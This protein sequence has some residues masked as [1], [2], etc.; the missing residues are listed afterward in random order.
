MDIDH[1]PTAAQIAD[2]LAV[3]KMNVVTVSSV[4][5]GLWA[6][7]GACDADVCVTTPEKALGVLRSGWRGKPVIVIGQKKDLARGVLPAV[8]VVATPVKH[9]RLVAALQVAVTEHAASTLD[10]PLHDDPSML[11]ELSAKLGAARVQAAGVPAGAPRHSLDNSALERRI[12]LLSEEALQACQQASESQDLCNGLPSC[13]AK[14]SRCWRPGLSTVRSTSSASPVA[15]PASPENSDADGCANGT[16]PEP[17]PAPRILIAEDNAINVRV[18][19][20]V[21]KH[22]R[23][24]AVVDVACNG[25]EVL[26][27]VERVRYDLILMDIHMPGEWKRSLYPMFVA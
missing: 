12:L 26:K 2:S 14:P 22:V 10:A 17:L 13:S 24:D 4:R 16:P 27:A 25:L 7:P 18:V 23:P 1:A 15:R 9:D 8:T 5:E 11:L 6:A 3:E 20:R 19:L 21:L